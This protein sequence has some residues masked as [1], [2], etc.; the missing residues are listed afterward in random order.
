MKGGRFEILLASPVTGDE[1]QR[2]QAELEA[3]CDRFLSWPETPKTPLHGLLRLRHLASPLPVSVISD[4]SPAGAERVR[5]AIGQADLVVF[6]FLHAMVL[7]PERIERPCLIFTHNVEAEIFRR[8][9]EVARNP[10]KRAVW[11]QQFR[12]M[13]AYEEASLKRA[14][15]VVAVSERDA[16][17]FA[18]VPGMPPVETIPTGV[19]LDFFQAQPPGEDD[20]IVFTG[21]MDWQANI[22]GIDFFMDAIWPHVVAQRPQAHV[23]I[24]G[25]NPNPALVERAKRRQLP[26]RFTGFVDDIRPEVKG[27]AAYII[28]LRV[29][30]GTRIKAFEAMAMGIPVVS[31]ALG[32]EGLPVTPDE[33]YLQG[34]TGEA[35]AA[36]LVRLLDD[37]S[38]RQ[39]LSRTARGYVEESFSSQAVARRFEAICMQ[40][41]HADSTGSAS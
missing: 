23:T 19:D 39:S 24:V 8:H 14:D 33:H 35:F 28:P 18:A 16:E 7:A 4:R 6:D 11:Q 21:A 2:Y 32:V 37:S 30:G 29:G 27:A 17:T 38:L 26:F 31:T 36:A 41:L 34:D 13:Q 10:L 22:D 25:R 12:K 20:H 9:A 3:V 15:T 1:A 40:T 5:D